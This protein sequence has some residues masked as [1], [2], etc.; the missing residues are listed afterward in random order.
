MAYGNMRPMM[1]PKSRRQPRAGT[2]GAPSKT[3]KGDLDYT[4]KRG[5]KDFHQRHHDILK[6]KRPFEDVAKHVR[7]STCPMH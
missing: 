2:K 7:K 4:T 5:N 1:R 6:G 3:R